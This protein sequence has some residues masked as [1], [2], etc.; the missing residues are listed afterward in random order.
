MAE[1]MSW[2]YEK[3]DEKGRVRWA[4]PNDA[5]GKITGHHVFGLKAWFDENPDE[6]IRLGYIKHITH[7][8][9]GIDYDP[10]TQYLVNSIKR[11]DDH[12]IEDDWQIM[13]MSPEQMRL[14]EL[15]TNGAWFDDDG[16]A[17]TGGEFAWI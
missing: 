7:K 10:A 15:S 6:R 9:E 14:R 11:V 8:T 2:H 3:L 4:P 13:D 1:E 16:V 17:V 5:D 12:T